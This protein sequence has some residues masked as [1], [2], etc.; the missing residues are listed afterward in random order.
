M[1]RVLMYVV[2]R[3]Q[4]RPGNDMFVHFVTCSRWG[5]TV[6]KGYVVEQNTV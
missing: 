1:T 4:Q 2:V 3:V 6:Y 5:S